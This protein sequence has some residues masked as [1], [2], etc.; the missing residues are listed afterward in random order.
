MK[1]IF[2]VLFLVACTQKEIVDV[3]GG[4]AVLAKAMALPCL[5]DVDSPQI[6]DGCGNDPRNYAP[7]SELYAGGNVMPANHRTQGEVSGLEVQPIEGKIRVAAEGHS[8]AL[9]VFDAFSTLLDNSSLHNS[10]IR[11]VN[12][13]TGGM[14]L[15]NWVAAGVGTVDTRVQ[16]VLLHHSLNK[17]FGNCS[18]QTYA[19]STAYYLRARV[20]QLKVKYPN[21]KQIFLQ[22]REFGGWKCYSS[23]GSQAEPAA[24]FNGFGVK[25][26]VD[27]Q[28]SGSDPSLS[29]A[30]APFMAWSFNPW[31][32]TTPRSWF[33]G[34]GLH[35]CSTGANFWAQEWFEFLLND[36]TTRSWFAANP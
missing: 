22:S 2:L 13:A 10:K 9:R 16:V 36:S 27:L 31:D 14:A 18:Q 17:A 5:S 7:M 30:N 29:Y 19:D 1:K 28:V 32:P 8:N 3:G 20:L 4:G 26:F 11:F 35:P 6:V 34:A 24:Y 23:P 15:E 33:E 12:N 25:A 21:V